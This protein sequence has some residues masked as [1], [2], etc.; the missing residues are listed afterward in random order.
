MSRAVLQLQSDRLAR[1][2]ESDRKG[3]FIFDGLPAGNYQLSAFAAGYPM[4]NHLLATPR[5]LSIKGKSCVRQIFVL[6]S[7]GN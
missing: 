5:R 2:S 6:P 7:S 4:T 1:H 3:R